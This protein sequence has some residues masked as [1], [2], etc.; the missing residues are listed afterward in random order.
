M[1]SLYFSESSKRTKEKRQKGVTLYLMNVWN[2]KSDNYMIKNVRKSR[3]SFINMSYVT[4]SPFIN[5][6][7]IL[8][9]KKVQNRLLTV[10][11]IISYSK[12]LFIGVIRLHQEW[13]LPST[14]FFLYCE[15]MKERNFV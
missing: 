13:V 5:S 12:K 8:H 4:S 10:L 14:S 6:I 1:K 3:G 9:R 2:I 15:A 11:A 7:I